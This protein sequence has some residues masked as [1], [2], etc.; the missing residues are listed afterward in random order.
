VNGNISP[1]SFP[2]QLGGIRSFS[3]ARL[4]LASWQRAEQSKSARYLTAAL[5]LIHL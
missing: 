3:K 2:K 4:L 5:L 1:L